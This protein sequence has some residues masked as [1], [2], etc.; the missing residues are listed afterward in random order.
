M[1]NRR[2]FHMRPLTLLLAVV[3]LS[4]GFLRA[5][6]IK[7]Q[8]PDP[9]P[10]LLLHLQSEKYA[11]RLESLLAGPDAF[12][13]GDELVFLAELRTRTA[14]SQWLVRLEWI[15][16]E[17]AK[18][19]SVRRFART[20]DVFEYS[21]DKGIMRVTTTGPVELNA[22][23]KPASVSEVIEVERDFLLLGFHE[24]SGLWE[25]MDRRRAQDPAL[26]KFWFYTTGSKA[27]DPQTV[28]R[29]KAIMAAYRVTPGQLRALGG[30]GVAFDAFFGQMN[31]TPGVS[32]ILWGIAEKPSVFSLLRGLRTD[33]SNYVS[34]IAVEPSAWGLPPGGSCLTTSLQVMLNGKPAIRVDLFVL[35]ARGVML[36]SAGVVGF[37]AR[38]GESDGDKTL[39]VRRVGAK[40]KER[41][42]PQAMLDMPR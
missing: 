31:R 9:A 10:A 13:S 26:P 42:D 12:A 22:T 40:R 1:N 2:P 25:E 37:I 14:R 39:V 32:E 30:F 34:D 23:G 16:D 8:L 27:V 20:G 38:P 15:S 19:R 24:C 4:S 28:A 18:G 5:D 41:A 11:T 6:S 29:Q 35:P 36:A 3:S 33:V 21:T 7:V 17:G